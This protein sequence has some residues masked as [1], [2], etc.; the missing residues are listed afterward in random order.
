[1]NTLLSKFKW[2]SMIKKEEV[3]GD[4]PSNKAI[5]KKTFDIAWPS[6]LESVLIALI[7]AVDMMMV[8]ALG[9]EAINAVGIAT[10]PKFIVLAPIFALNIGVTVLVSRRKGEQKQSEANAYLRNAL[11]IGIGASFILS[12]SA[13]IF[14]KPFLLFAGA[15]SDYLETGITY[16]RVIMVGNFFYSSGLTM[17]AAQRGAGNTKISMTTNL[18]AN[19][20]NL[21]FNALLINGLFF[22]PRLEVLGAAIATAFGNFVSFCMAYYSLRHKDRYLYLDLHESWRIDKKYVGDIM[23][24][25]SSSL[26]EQMFLRMGFF[27]YAKSIAILGTIAFATHQLCMNIMSISFAFGDGLQIANTSLVG[28]SLGA[29]RPDM[30]KIH[31]KVTQMIGIIVGVIL[32]LIVVVFRKELLGLFTTDTAVIDMGK[33]PLLII[34]VTILFQVPQVI[35]V[36]ALRGAGDVKFVALLMLISVTGVRPLL[37]WLLCY[38]LGFGL[39]GAWIALFIDQMTRY[40]ISLWR[41]RQNKWSKIVV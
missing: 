15:N 33:I 2:Q 19:L 17:T 11:L 1:M 13:W 41:F 35:I 6:A 37:A 29:K 30:A 38:P 14:A 34:A 36:G 20:V 9:K 7:G 28:Q 25:S 5:Y 27:M 24:I 18:M 12:L 32:A 40:T 16:F 10:Q 26:I 31:S 3:L 23:K 8:G 39:I 22:F 21:I 4:I